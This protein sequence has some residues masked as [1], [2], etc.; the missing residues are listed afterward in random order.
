MVTPVTIKITY[1][2]SSMVGFNPATFF[3]FVLNH[4]TFGSRFSVDIIGVVKCNSRY[5]GVQVE[6]KMVQ[7]V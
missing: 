2:K 4:S 3:C 1:A 7:L 6:I 5:F